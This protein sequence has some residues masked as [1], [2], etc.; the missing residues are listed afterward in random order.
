VEKEKKFY[1][2]CPAVSSNDIW[3]VSCNIVDDN[4]IETLA[5]IISMQTSQGV[6]YDKTFYGRN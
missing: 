1:E 6:L 3:Q 5:P 2:I 4:D